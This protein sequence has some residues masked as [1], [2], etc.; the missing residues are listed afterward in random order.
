MQ[1]LNA[2]EIAHVSGGVFHVHST[3]VWMQKTGRRRA[4]VQIDMRQSS[5]PK[6]VAE[7][8]TGRNRIGTEHC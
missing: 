4:K 6:A 1:R 7:A 8:T 5:H 2:T 3:V